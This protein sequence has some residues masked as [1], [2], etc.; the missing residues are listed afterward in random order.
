MNTLRIGLTGNMGSGKTTVARIFGCLGIPVYNADDAAKGMYRRKEVLEQ[1]VSLTGDDIIDRS[2][3]LDK[4]LLAEKIFSDSLLLQQ[5]NGIIHPLVRED[6]RRWLSHYTSH[7]YVIH[8]AAILHE[9]GFRNEYDRVIHVSCP[10]Q[11]A[12]ERIVKRDGLPME[13]IR[14]RMQ[15]QW[16]DRKKASL[17]DFTIVNDG[18]TMVIPQVLSVHRKLSESK[19]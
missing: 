5:I 11:V 1:V 9:S 4:A 3:S 12:M 19:A 14:R 17:S 15:F 7:H 18:K 2:G 10:E 8:E 6:F 13:K 16:D